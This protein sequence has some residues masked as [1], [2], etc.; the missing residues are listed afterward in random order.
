MGQLGVVGGQGGVVELAGPLRIEP[1]VELVFPA[2]LET[3]L[4]KGIVA[5]LGAGMALGQVGGVSGDLV[6]NDSFLDILPLGQAQVFLGSDVAKHGGAVPSDHG[7][8]DG[9]GDV[10]ISGGHIGR[11]G[12][13]GIEGRFPAG[14][15]LAGHVLPD[16]LHGNVTGA[17][18]HGLHV[19]LPGDLG[20]LA[21]G[22]QL[23]ELG[24]V[25]GIG[26][27]ARPQPV[28][29][30]EGDVVGLHDLA[31]FLEMGVEEVLAVVGQAPLG[32]NGAA[33][34]DDAGDPLG[35]QGDIAQPYAG[36]Y[37]E[38]IDT[39][40]G[41]F[42][43]GVSKDLPGEFFGFALD[44]LQGLVDGHGADGNRAVAKNPFPGLM[45]VGS[46]GQVHHRVGAPSDRP[47]HLFHFLLDGGGNG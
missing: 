7:G 22:V 10:V 6:S 32:Q 16:Q 18:D 26:D 33:A 23:R 25:V 34:R 27:G 41:L 19:V 8:A 1:Q 11:Q 38:V 3:S 37:G 20:Q 43:Q 47:H 29:Q 21:Q 12:T 24:L 35:R 9:A 4:G 5:R 17:L 44:L 40:L 36:M 46:G 30:A 2:K 39:L 28:A 15:E 45:N 14:L 42:H 13:E 31:D